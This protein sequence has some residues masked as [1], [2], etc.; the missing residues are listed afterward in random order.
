MHATSDTSANFYQKA[1]DYTGYGGMQYYSSSTCES[2]GVVTGCKN[3]YLSSEVKYVVDAWANARVSIGLQEA[4]LISKNEYEPMII[5]ETYETP[6]QPG[7]R[8]IPLYDWQE[9]KCS[10]WT[11]DVYEDST[12]RVW[13][14]GRYSDISNTTI[15]ISS[16]DF[17]CVRPVIVLDKSVLSA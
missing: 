3:D 17:Y 6:T 9:T 8:I 15:G 13:T 4:R 16:G 14:I 11:S 12:D 10:W 2:Y 7:K 1:F 5:I